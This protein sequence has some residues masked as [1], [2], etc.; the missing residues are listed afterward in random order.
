MGE[1]GNDSD[2]Q[3]VDNE[4]SGNVYGSAGQFGNVYGDVHIYGPS[5][6]PRP[7]SNEPSKRDDASE[8]SKRTK[9]DR[10]EDER[11]RRAEAERAR[12][13]RREEDQK[14]AIAAHAGCRPGCCH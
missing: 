9:R 6:T 13:Q 2:R 3:D 11:K 1:P 10:A 14:A 12:H 4:I 5:P 8:S 7:P